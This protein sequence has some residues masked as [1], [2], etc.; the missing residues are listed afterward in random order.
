[1]TFEGH[2]RYNKRFRC[3]Y[4]KH[5]ASIMY[6]VNYNSRTS[7]VSYYLYCRLRPEELLYDAKRDL[8]ATAKFLVINTPSRRRVCNNGVHFNKMSILAP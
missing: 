3:L 1:M 2:F 6:E 4:L 8:S 5:P 7:R